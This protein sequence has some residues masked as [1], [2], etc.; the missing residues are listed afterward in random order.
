MTDNGAEL[1]RAIR[2]IRDFYNDVGQLLVTAQ[3]L[4]AEHGWETARDS[5]CLF[6]LSY[7]ASQ[8]K[9]WLPRFAIRKMTNPEAYPRVIATV[10][11]LLDDVD[12]SSKLD[13]PVVTAGF[14]LMSSDQ[15]ELENWNACGFGWRGWAADGKPH[16]VTDTDPNWK[17]NWGWRWHEGFAQPL[18][19]VTDQASL[20]ALVVK[21]LLAM[22]SAYKGF[23]TNA[24][25][26]T[27]GPG[28]LTGGEQP[29][30]T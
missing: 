3:T 22:I 5:T 21:P 28:I 30:T 11:V 24:S 2:R 8:G 14:F 10:S 4:M 13:E 7:S 1:L 12:A 6:G 15:G 26:D 20:E 18:V 16:T 19:S 17:S 25:P 23:A 27:Q 29:Q 9:Q